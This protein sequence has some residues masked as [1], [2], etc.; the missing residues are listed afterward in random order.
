[1]KSKRV[2]RRKRSD[3]LEYKERNPFKAVLIYF[4]SVVFATIGDVYSKMIFMR[5]QQLSI[6]EFSIYRF[7][8]Q[9]LI[10]M[11]LSITKFKKILHVP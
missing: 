1:M 10:I 9:V 5:K 2:R 6:L 3:P 11:L 7:S 4:F 8:I